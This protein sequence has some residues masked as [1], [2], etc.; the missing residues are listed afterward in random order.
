[1]I[2]VFTNMLCTAYCCCTVCCGKNA[3]GIDATGQKPVQGITVAIPRRYPLGSTVIIEGHEYRGTD[4]YN[5]NLSPRIDIYF[6][7]HSDA[8]KFG[9]QYKRVTII[10]PKKG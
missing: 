10:T 2:A 1:M 5:K 8:V 6:L 4:R 7:L 3:K 9:K